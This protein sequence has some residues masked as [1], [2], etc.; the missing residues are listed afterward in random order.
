MLKSSPT[1]NEVSLVIRNNIHIIMWPFPVFTLVSADRSLRTRI[2]SSQVL[3]TSRVFQILVNA[4][5]S[6]G[7]YIEVST[8]ARRPFSL[9]RREMKTTKT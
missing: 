6:S 5:A 8:S 3:F 9:L 1:D 7:Y 2:T 4:A